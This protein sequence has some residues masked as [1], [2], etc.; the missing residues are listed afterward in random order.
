MLHIYQLNVLSNAVFMHKISSETHP[1]VFHSR[2]LRLSPSSEDFDQEYELN[3]EGYRDLIQLMRFHVDRII[4]LLAKI[5]LMS[6][7]FQLFLFS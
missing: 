1:F 5:I 4:F 3:Q 2:V 6:Q 7:L